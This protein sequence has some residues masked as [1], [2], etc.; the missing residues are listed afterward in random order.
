[1]KQ[2]SLGLD[3]DQWLA[4]LEKASTT[5]RQRDPAAKTSAEL[6]AIWGVGL[7]KTRK[8]IGQMIRDGRLT[9]VHVP[10]V[11]IVGRTVPVP[12]YRLVR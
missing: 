6:Q 10:T 4:I 5:T 2:E 7:G 1:M 11:D 12:A 3:R 9:I 8:L